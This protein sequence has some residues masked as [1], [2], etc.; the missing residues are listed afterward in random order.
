M[1]IVRAENPNVDAVRAAIERSL[2][3]IRFNFKRDLKRVAIKPNLCYYYDYTTGETTDPQFVGA[4][5]DV[6]R[7]KLPSNPEIFIVESD[8]SAVRCEHA[9]RM[10]G[11]VKMAREKDVTLVNLS[12]EENEIVEV[13]IIDK[14]FTFRVPKIFQRSDLF[15]NVP[16]IKYQSGVKITCA[17]KNIYGCNGYPKKYVYHRF[18][19]E[20]IVGINKLI[21]SDLVVVDGITVAGTETRKLGLVMASEDAVAVDSVASTILGINPKAVK[22]IALAEKMDLGNTQ[23]VTKGEALDSI[24]NIFPRRRMKNKVREFAAS[25]Y[26]RLMK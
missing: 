13:K 23:F 3:L 19:H 7:K 20:A 4:L 26:L 17:L 9:F 11:Y 18:V 14:Y 6:L 24:I 1:S 21:K 22:Q 12:K 8:A 16:K 15:I 25:T 2:S 5:V 10:L